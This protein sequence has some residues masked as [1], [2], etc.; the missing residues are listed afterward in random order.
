MYF[1]K[2]ALSLNV[3]STAATSTLDT[4]TN[5]LADSK[6]FPDEHKNHQERL[7]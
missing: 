4:G 6:L 5:H 7:K 2:I 3:I 1:L